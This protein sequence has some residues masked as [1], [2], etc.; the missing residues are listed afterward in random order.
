MKKIAAVFSTTVLTLALLSGCGQAAEQPKQGATQPAQGGNQATQ[1]EASK[2][3][4][5]LAEFPAVVLPYKVDPNTVI[6]EY[7]GGK[8]T[9][10]ELETFL[11]T[12][13]F[14]N[15]QQGAM[16]QHADSNAVKDYVRQYVA[17]KILAQRSDETMKAEALK[18]AEATFDNY[19]KQYTERLEKNE[20]N[21]TK[22]LEAQGVTKE[23]LLEQ[24]QLINS[25][26]SVLDKGID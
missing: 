18:Q 17:T 22:L 8:L 7:Q 20:Q 25:S 15:P 6:A 19:K 14:L 1:P 4:D 24:M 3:N 23:Q 21:F 16:V 26:I 9:A 5:A 12:I 10:K 11:R 13:N 2:P